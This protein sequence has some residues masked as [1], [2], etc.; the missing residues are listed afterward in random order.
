[1]KIVGI[2]LNKTGTSTLGAAGAAMG[3][4]CKTWDPALFR[5]TI[6]KGHRDALWAT[7]DA[8]DLFND[9][10]Y[11]LLY[12]EIDAR[13]P[14]A[15]FVLTRRASPEAWLSSLK[16]HAM[17]GAIT[18]RTHKIVYG[19]Q[20][21]HGRESAFLDYYERHNEEA[22]RYFADRP[23][24]FLEI[25]WEEE[26]DW[27]RFASFLGKPAPTAPLPRANARAAKKI[28]PM[29]YAWNIGGRFLQNLPPKA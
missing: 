21:P 15:K 27:T 22:R 20:Y 12:R 23:A 8:F 5:A 18:T 29:R 4:S 3:L 19:W 26:K 24:D 7:I 9:F 25:C 11:P 13:Y 14:G 2:G 10:P 6:V 17:R 16:A 1:M 28:N